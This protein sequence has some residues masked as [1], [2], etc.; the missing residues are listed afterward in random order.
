MVRA[1]LLE[2]VVLKLS[3]IIKLSNCHKLAQ[4]KK[5]LLSLEEGSESAKKRYYKGLDLLESTPI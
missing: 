2:K 4:S 5:E 3:L 1:Q